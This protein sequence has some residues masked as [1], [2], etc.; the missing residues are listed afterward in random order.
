MK[1]DKARNLSKLLI[2]M[3]LVFCIAGLFFQGSTYAGVLMLLS[4]VFFVA[5]IVVIAAFCRCPYC[6]KHI[7]FGLFKIKTC[8][9]CR[10]DLITGAKRRKG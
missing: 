6:G 5:T 3:C 10:R 4:T 8:P 7:Y 1:F 9:K 2:A